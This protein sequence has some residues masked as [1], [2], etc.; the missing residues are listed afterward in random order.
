M[1]FD[2]TVDTDERDDGIPEDD[3]ERF[4][5]LYTEW[6]KQHDE[7]PTVGGFQ[8]WQFGHYEYDED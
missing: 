8:R 5:E 6:C 3:L 7:Q 2:Q 4:Y 1:S